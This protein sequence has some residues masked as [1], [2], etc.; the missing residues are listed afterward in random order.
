MMD[1]EQE[2][3]QMDHDVKVLELQ[4]REKEQESKLAE[5]KIKELKRTLRHK[6]LKPLNSP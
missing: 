6:S 3:E 2:L 5:L 4:V 1:Q